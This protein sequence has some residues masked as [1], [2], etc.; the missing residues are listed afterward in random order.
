MTEILIKPRVLFVLQNAYQ[1]S[2]YDWKNEDE[3]HR[4][5]DKSHTGR[6]LR[7]MIP[8]GI[9]FYVTN[10]SPKIGSHPDSRFLADADHLIRMI[11]KYKPHL[12]CACGKVAQDGV[13]MLGVHWIS[14]PHPAWRALS[15]RH[16]SR[17]RRMIRAKMENL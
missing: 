8:D 11:Q 15:K 17:I 4:D 3:W 16:T 9:E 7:E 6:R 13:A 14:A 5:L 12:V 2:K 1:S 10:A